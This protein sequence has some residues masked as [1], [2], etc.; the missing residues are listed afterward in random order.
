MRLPK[1]PLPEP[2]HYGYFAFLFF[3]LI[4]SLCGCGAVLLPG[5]AG[6]WETGGG[7]R[8]PPCQCVDPADT[9]HPSLNPLCKED[10]P[11]PNYFLWHRATRAQPHAPLG[12]TWQQVPAPHR[13]I[14]LPATGQ[15]LTGINTSTSPLTTCLSIRGADLPAPHAAGGG[16]AQSR[17]ASRPAG[18]R[19]PG[20]EGAAGA[21]A[22][23]E[24]WCLLGT[25][26]QGAGGESPPAAPTLPNH[27][28][29]R[30]RITCSQRST[31]A[32][33]P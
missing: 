31:S 6:P 8:H 11:P 4:C 17:L 14:L 9:E 32:H 5:A 26:W 25:P 13:L 3:T 21:S 20:G 22:E 24:A 2:C 16:A 30:Q 28:H 1:P 19:V 29:P 7:G 10:T 12:G 23:P 27:D 33:Y 15:G 18:H